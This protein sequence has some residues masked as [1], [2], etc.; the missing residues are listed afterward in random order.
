MAELIA[1]VSKQSLSLVERIRRAWD[2]GDAISVLDPDLPLPYLNALIDAVDPDWVEYQDSPAT[3][4]R[5]RY[6]LV[7]DAALVICT[8]G[9]S[10]TPKAVVHTAGNLAAS[11][12]ATGE[13]LRVTPGEG[14]WICALP[15]T[16]IGG[17]STIT[18]ALYQ[19][20]DL[21]VFANFDYAA[22]AAVARETPSY[23]PLV[24]ANLA[25]ISPEL[26]KHLI[27][28]AGVPPQELAR[29]ASVTY[30][31]TETGSG[32]V[33]DGVAL[34]GVDLRVAKDGEILL[35]GDMIATHYRDGSEI[36][37]A[38]GWF[39]TDDAG[40]VID[41]KLQVHGRRSELIYS[42]GEKIIPHLVEAEI[43]KLP[44]VED[45]AVVGVDD[46]DYQQVAWAF[47]VTKGGNTPPGI[48]EIKAV[49]RRALPHYYAPRGVSYLSSLPKTLLGK[50]QKN[51][52]REL[53]GPQKP[54]D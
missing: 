41:G 14:T 12:I 25:H 26:F 42:G 19:G 54:R 9:T 21:K 10:G 11:A 23:L 44:S 2:D 5:R 7:E 43:K 17:F 32:L 46:P 47:V 24:R 27:L 4:R 22:I 45:V 39:H 20:L 18:K 29:N 33:Y 38:D 36:Y 15:I 51:R 31:L 48:A 53:G 40:E 1:L 8:S 35:K 34:Q 28:G 16:H 52:L 13:Y 30:G 50:V 49:V 37:A 6:D 3:P